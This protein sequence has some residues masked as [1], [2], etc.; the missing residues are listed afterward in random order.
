MSD[1]AQPA[2]IVTMGELQRTLARI[3]AGQARV[4]NDHEERLRR[5]EHWMWAVP[6]TIMVA[7]GSVI[8][9]FV[10]AGGS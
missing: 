9:A 8:V 3:E 4:I 6:P 1:A 2:D 7:I 10:Q 5:V